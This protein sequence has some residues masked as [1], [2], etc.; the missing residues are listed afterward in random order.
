MRFATCLYSFI[1]AGYE[2]DSSTGKF[3]YSRNEVTSV[4]LNSLI[5]LAVAIPCRRT[6]WF[7]DL[8]TGTVL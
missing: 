8:P 3:D 5:T 4:C 6:G 1:R 2:K 7:R